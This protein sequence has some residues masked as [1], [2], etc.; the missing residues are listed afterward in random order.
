MADE[1][2]KA[3]DE[4][5]EDTRVAREGIEAELKEDLDKVKGAGSRPKRP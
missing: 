2:E 3:L 5:A 1:P 4:M